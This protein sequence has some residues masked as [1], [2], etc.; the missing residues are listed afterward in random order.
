MDS[1]IKNLVAILALSLLLTACE[2]S[3]PTLEGTWTWSEGAGSEKMTLTFYSNGRVVFKD[4]ETTLQGKFTE[5][6][7]GD[8]ICNWEDGSEEEFT[9]KNDRLEIGGSYP[10]RFR[11]K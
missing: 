9:R 11:K 10:V 2:K 7:P 6:V 8:I 3:S 1:H 4:E 5:P